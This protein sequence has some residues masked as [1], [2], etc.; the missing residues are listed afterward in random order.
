MYDNFYTKYDDAKIF[1]SAATA[2]D[3]IKML[4]KEKHLTAEQCAY[5]SKAYSFSTEED[6]L[7]KALKYA[8]KSVKLNPEYAY[9]YVRLAFA[10]GKA[11]KK[12][13]CLKSLELA[14]KFGAENWLVQVFLCCL[15]NYI[16]DD[17]KSDFY[18][19]KLLQAEENS[20]AYWYN[21]GFVYYAKSPE[22]YE[23]AFE[24]FEKA[25]N[26][27]DQYNLYYKMMDSYGEL[28]EV[29]NGL[30]Y[31][32]KCLKIK[33]SEDLLERQIQCY[34]YNEDY[35][36]AVKL[37]RQ[38]YRKD[39]D[40]RQAIIFL[41]FIAKRRGEYNKALKYLRFADY[42][43]E[44]NKYLYELTAE[45]YE[46]KKDYRSAIDFYKK[47]LKFDKYDDEIFLNISYEY[48]MLKEYKLADKY[49]DLAIEL[50]NKS[51]YSYYRKGNIMVAVERY[52]EAAEAYKICVE[53]APD[54]VDYYH[55]L[56]YSYSKTGQLELSL[57]Y[58]NRALLLDKENSYSYFRK[59]WALQEMGKYNDAIDF[60]QKCIEK[61]STY[62]DAYA[63]ISYCY[64]KL[65]EFKK[66]ILYANKAIMV[67]KDYAYS[68]YRK[69]WALH[70]LGKF[71]EAIDDYIEAIELDPGDVNNYL[72]ITGVFLDKQENL[73]ALEFANK[74]ILLDRA[75]GYAYYY[76]SV[77]LINLGKKL[78]A[79]KVYAKARELGFE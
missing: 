1:I 73:S 59:A 20:P 32:E 51:A 41:G 47:A 50:N 57:E 13:E 54:D 10:A 15:Y 28:G 67:N 5:L 49:A 76:K 21:L 39:F 6:R 69:A 3:V 65:E 63:N 52:E 53:L 43:R 70:S 77:A 71:D 37:S 24:C 58:A 18:L 48:S 64:S 19:D 40:K 4:E 11:S 61:D 42:T 56:S 8:K 44:A 72:G 27:K 75:C 9:G 78:E 46:A 30:K 45:V 74:A 29:E 60:Y 66:S 31:L 55:S 23:K 2:E 33:E 14:E 62:V 34:I 7:K 16:D 25:K 26:Y 38:Y 35:D 79:E 36:E 17:E 68:H 22:D 12:K